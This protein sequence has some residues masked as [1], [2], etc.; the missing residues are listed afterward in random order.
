[1][2]ERSGAGKR[3][4]KAALDWGPWNGYGGSSRRR[5]NLGGPRRFFQP[6]P[7][8]GDEGWSWMLVRTLS[9]PLLCADS[10]AGHA[11]IF[12][13]WQLAIGSRQLAVGSWDLTLST[14]PL[15][16]CLCLCLSLSFSD[17]AYVSPTHWNMHRGT[18]C[19]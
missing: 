13:I 7:M 2:V 10:A 18:V 11:S 17:S 4:W 14:L 15:C 6:R 9:S 12:G 5:R 16:L 1:M 3:C 19:A 8:S